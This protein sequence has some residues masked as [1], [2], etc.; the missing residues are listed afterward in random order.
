MLTKKTKYGRLN[1]CRELDLWLLTDLDGEE[2]PIQSGDR[3]TLGTIQGVA[4]Y[5]VLIRDGHAWEWAITDAPMQPT[6]GGLVSMQVV[7]TEAAITD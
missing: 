3:I 1:Y 6:Q 7:T 2:W 4:V 5:A